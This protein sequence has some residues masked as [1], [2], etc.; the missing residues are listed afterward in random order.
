LY[1]RC[2]KVCAN[3]DTVL[4]NR[5]PTCKVQ[6]SLALAELNKNGL[7]PRTHTHGPAFPS[8]SYMRSLVPLALSRSRSLSLAVSHS[9][10]STP[11]MRQEICSRP[12]RATCQTG[13]SPPLLAV[14]AK[15]RSGPTPQHTALLFRSFTTHVRISRRGGRGRG[16][17]A[18]TRALKKH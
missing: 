8:S 16:V 12:A 18:F 1:T 7:A 10:A 11:P 14:P 15:S 13:S 4:S 3:G 5:P 17:K 9:L 6:N 2:H